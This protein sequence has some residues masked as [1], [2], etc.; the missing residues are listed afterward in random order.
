LEKKKVAITGSVGVQEKNAK[1]DVKLI[2]AALNLTRTSRLPTPNLA[3]DGLIG[4]NTLTAIETFQRDSMN[5]E[6]PDSGIEPNGP[7]IQRLRASISKGLNVNSLRAIMGHSSSKT[8][9]PY[10]PILSTLLGKYRVNTPL[11]IAHFL[12]QVG[13]ESLSLRYT[14]EIASGQAYEGRVDLGNIQKGDGPRFKGRGLIQL[15]G[16]SN[17]E[18]YGAH[19]NLNLLKKGN[20]SLI[21]KNPRY[22]VDASLWFWDTRNLNRYADEDNLRAV[23]RRVNGGF[24]GLEDRKS[25]LN[26]AKFFL[27]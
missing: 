26:R 3:V 22:A 16:R 25:Y 2:Q 13:H 24:N 18:Q 11:R 7:T 6:R 12:A 19:A 4:K 23:T 21:A 5:M 17:Y 8:V 10:F 15:T 1:I 14:E 20:E 27:L 9:D